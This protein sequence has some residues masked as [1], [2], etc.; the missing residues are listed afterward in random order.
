MEVGALPYSK[1]KALLLAEK[2][3]RTKTKEKLNYNGSS[4]C[5]VFIQDFRCY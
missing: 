4:K 2:H 1:Y 3:V 5:T